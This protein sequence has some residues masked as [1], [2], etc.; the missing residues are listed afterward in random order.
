MPIRDG[1]DKSSG[2]HFVQYGRDGAKYF[3][4]A[5]SD[6]SYQIALNK[7][8]KQAAAIHISKNKQKK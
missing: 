1:I 3:Y 7:A 5:D 4:K 8:L 6:R 2:K